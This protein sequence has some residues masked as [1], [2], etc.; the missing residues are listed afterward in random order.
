VKENAEVISI[1]YLYTEGV[2]GMVESIGIYASEVS[3]I[4]DG[5]NYLEL[6]DN[7]DFIVMNEIVLMHVE[8]DNE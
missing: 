7:E 2:Y 3:Y 5:I 1:V 6:V 4:K 8:E